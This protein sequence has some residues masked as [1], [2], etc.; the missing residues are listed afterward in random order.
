M[1]TLTRW[2]KNNKLGVYQYIT[3]HSAD[4]DE[5]GVDIDYHVSGVVKQQDDG[6]WHWEAVDPVLSDA[7]SENIRVNGVVDTLKRACNK[8][9]ETRGRTRQREA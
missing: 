8:V 2:Y 4:F 3:V 6:K 1:K 7:V 9:V 5:P